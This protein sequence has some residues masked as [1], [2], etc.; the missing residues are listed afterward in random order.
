MRDSGFGKSIPKGKV[1]CRQTCEEVL[2]SLPLE[3]LK[4]WH[5]EDVG[6]W[7]ARSAGFRLDPMILELFSNLPDPILAGAAGEY[8][9]K[10]VTSHSVW[11]HAKD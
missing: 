10:G 8:P 11:L 5:L 3:V 1:P 4:L 2:G 6:W 9:A 7:C